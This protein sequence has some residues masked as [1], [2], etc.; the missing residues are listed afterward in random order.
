MRAEAG[1]LYVVATPIGNLE[2]ITPRALE[3]LKSVDVIACENR[4]RHVKLLNRYEIKNRTIEYSPSNEVNSAKGIVK[5]LEEGKNIALVSDAGTPGLSDPGRVLLEFAHNAGIK[6][7][8]I[9]GVSALTALISVSGFSSKRLVFLGFLPKKDGKATKEISIFK[10]IECVIVLFCS[11]YRI[12]KLLN[13]V[14]NV[15]GNSD[16]IIGREIT[17]INEELL[18]GTAAELLQTNFTEKGEFCLAINNKKKK[19]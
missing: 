10:D 17:K 14:N 5:M 8:P 12:K 1:T 16:I 9:P 4:N 18:R 6:V 13:I 2:D 3:T 19:P 7:V 15:F 11:Q